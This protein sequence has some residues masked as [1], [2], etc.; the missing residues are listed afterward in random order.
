MRYIL[1]IVI[2]IGALYY[3]FGDKL[4]DKVDASDLLGV[5]KMEDKAFIELRND[6]VCQLVKVD[7]S[8][9]S[10]L[11]CYK[12]KRVSLSGKWDYK[13]NYRNLPFMQNNKL[14]LVIKDD[15]S[16]VIYKLAFS[17]KSGR[18]LL[19]ERKFIKLCTQTLE[20]K[21][22]EWSKSF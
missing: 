16:D 3:L 5:W 9:F 4:I 21:K 10:N 2:L 7:F 18:N 13:A 12:G 11:D 22:Y 6:G 19:G 1:F 20:I 15:E 17:V 14:W 8:Q